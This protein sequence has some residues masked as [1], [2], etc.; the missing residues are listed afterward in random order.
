MPQQDV[1]PDEDQREADLHPIRFAVDDWKVWREPEHDLGDAVLISGW[2]EGCIRYSCEI[3]LRNESGTEEE[4]H[5][6]RI[7][8]RQGETVLLADTYAFDDRG[9]TLPPNG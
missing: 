7:E 2:R 4:I 6:L 9:V 3:R 1:A 8:F 5:R